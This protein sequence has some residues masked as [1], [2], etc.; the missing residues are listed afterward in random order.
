MVSRFAGSLQR[1]PSIK[2]LKAAEKV[3]PEAT[4]GLSM[5]FQNKSYLSFH[6]KVYH[7][8]L[9]FAALNAGCPAIKMNRICPAAKRSVDAG[10]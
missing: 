3:L 10:E 1:R 5:A 9:I 4:R 2:D 6:I 8:S 7:G